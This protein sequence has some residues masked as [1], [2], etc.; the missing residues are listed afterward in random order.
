M[1]QK[2]SERDEHLFTLALS[3][4][5]WGVHFLASYATAAIW[6][7]KF[8]EPGGSL[9]TARAVIGALTVTALGAIALVG[10]RAWRR[11]RYDDASL[12][13]DF[14]SPQDR[15]RFLGFATA[16]LSG[17]SAVAVAY[18]GLAVVFIESCR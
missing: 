1:E 7:A 15:H 13:H 4:A 3:P 9:A 12:P 6:C 18:E 8:V 17:L 2:L 5:I 11:H 14:D 16:L 10:R